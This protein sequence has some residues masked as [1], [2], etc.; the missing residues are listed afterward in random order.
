MLQR[1]P[2]AEKVK[3]L[4]SNRA[5]ADA[6]LAQN[7]D[8]SSDQKTRMICCGIIKSRADHLFKQKL[9]DEARIT[10]IDAIAAIVGKDFKIPLP[11]KGG[12]RN[13]SYVKNNVWDKIA[14][15]ECCNALA[16]CMIEL[17]DVEQ[18]RS[19]FFLPFQ[20]DASEFFARLYGG[21]RKL[22]SC[23]RTPTFPA[24]P[25]ISVYKYIFNTDPRF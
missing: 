19:G 9:Y 20:K 16:R 3:E 5:N 14:L 17:K 7:R 21:P 6:F 18:V 15:M 24:S 8:L 11:V 23:G 12:L 13:E 1:R 2:G 4:Q 22:I 10:Y 25:F